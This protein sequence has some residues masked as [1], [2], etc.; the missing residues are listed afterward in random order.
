MNRSF[1]V[2]LPTFNGQK[3]IAEAIESSLAQTLTPHRI[4]IVAMAQQTAPNV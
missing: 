3:Y 4:I 2:V 1:S